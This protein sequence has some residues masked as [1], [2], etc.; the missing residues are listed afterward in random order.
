MSLLPT[1]KIMMPNIEIFNISSSHRKEMMITIA[2]TELSISPGKLMDN[3]IDVRNV[4]ASNFQYY[5][6]NADNVL[7]K[8]YSLV[9]LSLYNSDHPNVTTIK[10]MSAKAN[11]IDNIMRIDNIHIETQMMKAKGRGS[12]NLITK[13]ANF[14]MTGQIKEYD[15]IDGAYQ[16]V[17][18]DE[19]NGEELPITIS[20]ELD[21]LSISINLNEIAIK[22]VEPIKNKI[23]DEIKDKVFDEI[24][25]KLKLPF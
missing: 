24:N 19:L 18:P 22:K 8:A 14:K 16:R 13:V 2:R 17:Y 11:I 5:G 6:I 7:L 9:K 20:G 15:N 10:N 12:I 1:T 23:I 3:I 4:K 21:D 25:D